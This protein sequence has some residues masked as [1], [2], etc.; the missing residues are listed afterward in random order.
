MG[1]TRNKWLGEAEI[2]RSVE[3][4]LADEK[5]G[6]GVRLLLNYIDELEKI[7]KRLSQESIALA[8]IIRDQNKKIE[9]IED[10]IDRLK[11][12]RIM[13][14]KEDENNDRPRPSGHMRQHGRQNKGTYRS[15]EVRSKRNWW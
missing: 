2:P 7:N 6:L 11:N 3:Q 13:K 4:F 8:K 14:Q 9:V 12:N 15:A 5:S 10:D 1:K